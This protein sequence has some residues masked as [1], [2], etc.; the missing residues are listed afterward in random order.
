MKKPMYKLRYVWSSFW[1]RRKYDIRQFFY[2]TFNKKHRAL[3]REAKSTTWYDFSSVLTL[4]R[5]KLE[6]MVWC[7]EHR[8]TR[9]VG[10]SERVKQMKTAI[11]LITIAA[12]EVDTFEYTGLKDWKPEDSIEPLMKT[13]KCKVNVNVRN[14]RR[15]FKEDQLKFVMAH[16]HEIY[17]RKAW[18]LLWKYLDNYLMG[19]WD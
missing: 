14:A 10:A 15:F 16:P 12:D 1:Y 11:R 5:A 9:C 2:R 6:E 4:L 8:K 7:Y 13:Y 3:I 17:E 18:E 19:W